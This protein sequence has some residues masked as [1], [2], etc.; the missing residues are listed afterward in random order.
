MS[1]GNDD[2]NLS[3]SVFKNRL[4]SEV[5]RAQYQGQRTSTEPVDGFNKTS[6]IMSGITEE[7]EGGTG[8]NIITITFHPNREKRQFSFKES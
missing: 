7:G 2:E 8:E 5:Q 1:D 4:H 6:Q 3:S